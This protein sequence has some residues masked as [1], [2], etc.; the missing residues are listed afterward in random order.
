MNRS[1]LCAWVFGGGLVECDVGDGEIGAG[2]GFVGLVDEVVYMG[3]MMKMRTID[4]CFFELT[5]H[6][7]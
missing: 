2:G 4:A 1:R 3:L 7:S 6:P 5:F